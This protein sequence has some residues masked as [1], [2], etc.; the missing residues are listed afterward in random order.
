MSENLS[1]V[2]KEE[3][4]KSILVKEFEGGSLPDAIFVL[5][6]GIEYHETKGFRSPSYSG[7]DFAGITGSRAR[8]IAAAEIAKAFPSIAI[9]ATSQ[10][11]QEGEGEAQ[12]MA[13]ELNQMG[14]TPVL[15]E[16]ST[17]TLTELLEMIRMSEENG[18]SNI[19]VLT[20]GYHV[21]RVKVMYEKLESIEGLCDEDEI[22]MIQAFKTGEAKVAFVSAEDILVNTSH[23]YEH[24][25]EKVEQSDGYKK[26]VELEQK[27]IDDLEAGRY[28]VRRSN[29]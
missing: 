8:V 23:H 17:S 22:A 2:P 10:G 15:E 28:K 14:V 20:N 6:G 24:L 1:P 27:G 9:V 26:R 29:G 5:Q 13:K 11:D 4:Y 18:W 21:P 12:V 19:T 3:M 25:I 7:G 16:K